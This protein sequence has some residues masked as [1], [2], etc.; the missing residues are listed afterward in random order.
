MT[1]ERMEFAMPASAEV[2]FDAF[3]YHEW[4]HRWDSLVGATRVEG[5]APCPFVGATTENT[6]RGILGAL[7]M[8]TRFVSFDRPRIAAA[9]MEEPSFPFT[10]WAASM[11]HRAV[12]HGTS[13]LIYTYS[14]DVGP[15]A[16]RWA[17]APVVRRVFQAQT[18][19][20]FDLLARF[21]ALHAGEVEQWQRRRTVEVAPAGSG[22]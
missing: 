8:R 6:G 16:L 10:R 17:L 2:V 13:V 19:R 15:P 5:A 9:S 4:R 11:R 3:H 18:R 7:S 21:L 14:F 22:P 20:R 1:H 12:G